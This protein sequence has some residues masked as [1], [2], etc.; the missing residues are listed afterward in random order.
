MANLRFLAESDLA[1]ILE[2]GAF[3]FGWQIE[4]T[5]PA[6]FTSSEPLT[7]YSGDIG[8]VIDPDTGQAVSGRNATIALRL[9]SLTEAGY[10][11]IP[12]AIE[13]QS[14]KPWVVRFT[15][16]TLNSWLFKVKQSSPDRTLGIVTCNLELYYQL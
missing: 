4:L 9:S 1:F 15:D 11:E 6:G 14:S 10:S 8:L 3:G 12:R 16:I 2:D 7:G 13:N 5:S